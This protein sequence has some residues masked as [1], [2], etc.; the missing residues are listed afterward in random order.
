MDSGS[1]QQPTGRTYVSVSMGPSSSSMPPPLSSI[2]TTAAGG[3]VVAAVGGSTIVMKSTQQQQQQQTSQQAARLRRKLSTSDQLTVVAVRNAAPPMITISSSSAPPLASFSSNSSSSSIRFPTPSLPL[4]KRMSIDQREGTAAGTVVAH[5]K[6]EIAKMDALP[7]A[8][9]VQEI[10]IGRKEFLFP[11]AALSHEEF[12]QQQN[13]GRFH[14]MPPSKVAPGYSVQ[15]GSADIM[16]A[17]QSAK[18]GHTTIVKQNLTGVPAASH[19]IPVVQPGGATATT[20]AVLLPIQQQ[21]SSVALPQHGT[22]IGDYKRLTNPAT[23]TLKVYRPIVPKQQPTVHA[24]AA[25]AANSLP[26][27]TLPCSP[28]ITSVT[29]KAPLGQPQSGNI[30]VP[31]GVQGIIG[32]AGAPATLLVQQQQ[33]IVQQSHASFI[34]LQPGPFHQHVL[35]LGTTIKVTTTGFEE[36]LTTVANVS[37]LVPTGAPVGTTSVIVPNAPALV[38]TSVPVTQQTTAASSA[39]TKVIQNPK[40]STALIRPLTVNPSGSVCGTSIPPLYVQPINTS[41]A[42]KPT[43]SGSCLKPTSYAHPAITTSIGGVQSQRIIVA[44]ASSNCTDV[45]HQLKQHRNTAKK[46]PL[47]P[48]PKLAPFRTTTAVATQ[49]KPPPPPTPPPMQ[50]AVES[51]VIS[52]VEK[53]D[54]FVSGQDSA[55][56]VTTSKVDVKGAKEVSS[57]TVDS[58]TV[59]TVKA[60]TMES[61]E[62]FER[63]KEGNHPCQGQEEDAE[64]YLN[65]SLKEDVVEILEEHIDEGEEEEEEEEKEAEEKREQIDVNE[66]EEEHHSADEENRIEILDSSLDT[67]INEPQATK[68]MTP[69]K[70]SSKMYHREM[71]A[72]S[73][74]EVTPQKNT[75]SP[76]ADGVPNGGGG[77]SRISP[78]LQKRSLS[79]QQHPHPGSS[80]PFTLAPNNVTKGTAAPTLASSS[81]QTQRQ[82]LLRKRS[83]SVHVGF[84]SFGNGNFYERLKLDNGSTFRSFAAFINHSGGV[85]LEAAGEGGAVEEDRKMKRPPLKDATNETAEESAAAAPKGVALKQQERKDTL[86]RPSQDNVLLLC[87]EKF[88]MVSSSVVEGDETPPPTAVRRT[89]RRL[90]SIRRA[91]GLAE[92]DPTIKLDLNE[93]KE[94]GLGY[95]GSAELPHSKSKK[96]RLDENSIGG[97][98]GHVRSNSTSSESNTTMKQFGR[99]SL[100]QESSATV[101]GETKKGSKKSPAATVAGQG[102]GRQASIRHSIAGRAASESS[103]SVADDKDSKDGVGAGGQNGDD[104]TAVSD[105]LRWHD[106]IGYLDESRLHFDFNE[107]GLVQP[108]TA[109]QYER[110]CTTDVYAHLMKPVNQRKILPKIKSSGRRRGKSPE[111]RSYR[112]GVC[113]ARGNAAEF[114]TPDYCSIECLQQS[115]KPA[116]LKYI[117]HSTHALQHRGLPFG[118]LNP[119]EKVE[120]QEEQPSRAKKKKT[121]RAAEEDTQQKQQQQQQQVTVNP[122]TETPSTT[123]TTTTATTT[124]TT[125]NNSSDED[126]RSSLSLNSN[127]F[128]R[129][130]HLT[131][132]NPTSP[133]A[134]PTGATSDAPSPPAP[135]DAAADAEDEN[136]MSDCEFNWDQYLRHVNGEAAPL[137]LFGRQPFPTAPNKFRE[138]MK[139]EAIDPE[140]CSLFCVCTVAEVRGYRIKLHFDGYPANYD[141]WVNADSTDIFPPGWCRSTN[142]VL[143]PPSSYTGDK[144]KVFRWKDYLL[145]TGAT[146]PDH[147]SFAHVNKPCVKNDFEIGMV[148]EAD[149]LKKSGK[150]CVATVAD[151]L[152]DRILVHFD[153]WDERYDY[154]VNVQSPYIHPID[155]HIENKAKITAPP[156]WHKPF[157]WERYIRHKRH[158]YGGNR[159]ILPASKELFKTRPPVGFK[160]GQRVEVVDRKQQMIIRPATVV[161][162]DK[163]EVELCFDGWPQSYAFWLEDDSPNLHPPNWC[164]RTRHPLEPPPTYLNAAEVCDGTCEIQLCMGRGNAKFPDKKYHD[165]SA[166]CPYKRINWMPEIRKTL[167]ISHNLVQKHLTDVL[168]GMGLYEPADRR[169]SALPT[170]KNI[171]TAAPQARTDSP[172]LA[173]EAGPAKRSSTGAVAAS[174]DGVPFTK[175]LKQESGDLSISTSSDLASQV[176]LDAPMEASSK[177]RDIRNALANE[178]KGGDK[179]TNSVAAS[180]LP[181]TKDATLRVA[182]PVI[183]GYGPRLL[184]SYEVWRWNSRI[185]D[186][187]TERSSTGGMLRIKNP[188]NWTTDE[189]ARY[190]EQLPGCDECAT[191][192]RLEEITGKSLLSFTQDDLMKYMDIKVG[193]AIKVYNRIIHLRQLVTKKFIQLGS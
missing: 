24:T 125:I 7:P 143:Q 147:R 135:A 9:P 76:A 132:I 83:E 185:L 84:S 47:P 190:I 154:W 160:P 173:D 118:A 26:S 158:R 91:T 184:H 141:F 99:R 122:R 19:I 74:L 41:A 112:C 175:R 32:P 187:C 172:R 57:K 93:L 25:L 107:F 101:A 115:G 136:P 120:P 10:V 148:L 4:S 180:A 87:D 162:I 65:E 150:V 72:V 96:A 43:V 113:R 128:I 81:K 53:R 37:P 12:Q 11:A 77:A 13:M 94:L 23:S 176:R 30:N 181:T 137:E 75:E 127:T 182:L 108:M 22:T 97:A 16:S 179:P 152:G 63:E 45:V 92:L 189:T 129:R 142:R 79:V 126:S 192:I 60:G 50:A 15:F 139:L 27:L 44:P 145:Q 85:A 95:D 153:G 46:L 58:L 40:T 100:P 3:S 89:S 186:E 134:S 71:E 193:P 88:D 124:T 140:N 5:P 80:V 48:V 6:V 174:G 106:G 17:H 146:V 114:A 157:N 103:F 165:R 31:A 49:V 117:Q 104:Q 14:S 191:K 62:Q 64:E 121:K 66:A 178:Q 8:P 59:T 156:D 78:R 34:P 36:Q 170:V 163:Y 130:Q 73:R 109:E 166:E 52:F 131:T 149:D 168:P 68:M 98:F 2:P 55:A 21:Q 1:M 155:W 67:S 171:A 105:H 51:T 169:T 20:T 29:S 151:K 183:D 33:E 110:H 28:T 138:G 144:A 167:R 18:I 177:K 90:D 82:V 69:E 102:R 70:N 119:N 56:A 111:C 42:T 188:L 86:T 159:P 61:Y 39:V 38:A 116:V 123:T 161:A 133:P 35:P 164:A 54:A